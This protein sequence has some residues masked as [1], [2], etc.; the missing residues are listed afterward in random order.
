MR[1]ALR[2]ICEHFD[3]ELIRDCYEKGNRPFVPHMIR[4]EFEAEWLKD[5]MNDVDRVLHTDSFDVFFQ[6]DPF[7]QHVSNESL[8]FVVEP[9]CF[10]SCGWNIEWLTRCYPQAFASMSHR[11][12]I[13]SGSIAGSAAEYLKLLRLMMGTDEWVRCWDRSLDQQILN[14]LV[15]RGM[16]KGAGINYSLTSC[17]GGFLT[18][19]WCAI[20]DHLKRNEFNQVTSIAGSVPSYIHQYDRFPAF[21]SSLFAM[22]GL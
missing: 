19:Q 17:D 21:Q 13:C 12:I 7:A 5:H 15:W 14:Y 16:V 2:Q 3:V 22:C 6:G 18:V 8:L 1:P 9:H 4:Y 11:F 10:R 20:E